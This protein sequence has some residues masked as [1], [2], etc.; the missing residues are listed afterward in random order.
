MLAAPAAAGSPRADTPGILPAAEALSVLLVRAV[1][2]NDPEG[3]VLP[4]EDR[5]RATE[6]G[7]TR[8]EPDPTRL[9]AARARALMPRIAS[10]LPALA[11]A[12]RD[13]SV[14]FWVGAGL[15]AAAGIVGVASS[16]LGP[17]RRINVLSV[18]ILA[19][20]GWNLVV[21]LLLMTS[22]AVGRV[23]KRG[24]AAPSAASHRVLVWA[25]ERAAR[26]PAGVSDRA[27]ALARAATAA[28]LP[29]WRRVASPLVIARG[30]ALLHVAS[31]ALA[32]GLIVGMYVRGIAFE[33]RATWESTFLGPA[34]VHALL[35]A[36][37]G[38]AAAVLGQSVPDAAALGSMRAPGS[39]EAASIIH[40]F[41]MTA[42]LWVIAPRLVLAAIDAARARGKA[43][44]VVL[45]L[46]EPYYRRLLAEYRGDATNVF[47]VPYSGELDPAAA[48][49]LREGLQRLEGTPVALHVCPSV[50]YG[51]EAS[52]WLERALPGCRGTSPAAAQSGRWLALVVPLAQTPESEVHGELIRQLVERAAALRYRLILV[53]D[54]SGYRRR[55]AG[56]QAERRRVEER[57]EAWDRMAARRGLTP[58]HLDLAEGPAR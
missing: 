45:D 8:A 10:R 25:A 1:E 15:V 38:P 46:D 42:L 3:Q 32:A 26:L 7:R 49:A 21:Y 35:A 55:L 2:E 34:Q 40:L 47:A 23:F 33:Y 50:A 48:D 58:V 20:L 53:V 28:Y 5:R 36:I 41:A 9:I 39:G 16:A 22:A 12:A 27:S 54:A 11:A 17:S 43:R 31:A 57:R 18:P 37:L 24:T 51:A 44:R 4:L 29:E 19:V 30:R 14:P 13:V 52:E 6:Q 56:T